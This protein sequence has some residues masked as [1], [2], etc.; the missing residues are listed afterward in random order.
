M[1]KPAAQIPVAIIVRVSTSKQD[2]A[3][4]V[5]ELQAVADA[6]GWQVVEIVE[7]VVSGRAEAEERAGLHRI[8]ELA[9]AGKIKKV[10]VHE[11]SRLGRK[12]SIV[13]RFIEKMEDVGVSVYW[14]SQAVE[15][16]LASGKRNPAA[17]LMLAILAEMGRA[18][19]EQLRERI[20]S[21]LAEARRK[22]V[23][24]GRP[25]GKLGNAALVAKHPDI[26]RQLNAGQS[27]RNTAA[28]TGKG[29]STVQRVSRARGE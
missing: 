1:S 8:E 6:K 7:E 4:Q 23:K 18:E 5:S 20:N 17:A 19:V 21:G 11:V 28:I 15:T 3:R 14:H 10:L 2:T 16:L 26:V 13:H 9:R 24:L 12:T 22:G 29:L 27:L 25:E